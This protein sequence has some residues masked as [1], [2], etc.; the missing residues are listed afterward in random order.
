MIT[1]LFFTNLIIFF[2]VII[3]NR[4]TADTF[5]QGVISDYIDKD[6]VGSYTV[7]TYILLTCVSIP[8][9]LLYI[10]WGTV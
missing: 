3:V 8:A 10:I 4:S 6:T 5:K 1:Q 7:V 2:I 9:Y